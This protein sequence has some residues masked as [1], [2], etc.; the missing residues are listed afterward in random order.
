MAEISDTPFG[1]FK[2]KSATGPAGASRFELPSFTKGISPQLLIDNARSQGIITKEQQADFKNRVGKDRT[3]LAEFNEIVKKSKN[4]NL[5]YRGITPEQLEMIKE[6][7][8][9][10]M[11]AANKTARINLLKTTKTF[12]DEASAMDAP[13]EIKEQTF[14]KQMQKAF[15]DFADNP[16]VRKIAGRALML[17]NAF[18][19]ALDFLPMSVLEEGMGMLDQ[20]P[21][22]AAKGGI[23][24]IDEM[25]RPVG[26]R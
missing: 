21:E 9:F 1:D 10:P 6:K 23:M 17:L 3:A 20:E 25:I 22:S 11:T 15:G 14:L 18:P 4:P 7:K 5:Q 16:I 26:S 8:L 24:S 2:P 12:L 13:K 19:T